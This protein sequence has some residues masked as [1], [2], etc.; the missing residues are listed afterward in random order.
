MWQLVILLSVSFEAADA[1]AFAMLIGVQLMD[2]A[3]VQFLDFVL[4][5]FEAADLVRKRALTL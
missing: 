3:D 2:A 1:S 5:V 4:I